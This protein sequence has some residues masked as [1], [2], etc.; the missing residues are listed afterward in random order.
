MMAVYHPEKRIAQ[1]SGKKYS[2]HLIYFPKPLLILPHSAEKWPQLQALNS[3]FN[4]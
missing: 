1:F 3:V 2:M 4:A